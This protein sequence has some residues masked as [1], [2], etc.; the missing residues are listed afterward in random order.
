M[1]KK[2][3]NN[4]IKNIIE[5]RFQRARVYLLQNPNATIL[6]D[7]YYED[8]Q[9]LLKEYS[10]SFQQEIDDAFEE[11]KEEASDKILSLEDELEDAENKIDELETNIERLQEELDDT[12]NIRGLLEGKL[13]ILEEEIEKLQEKVNTNTYKQ[14]L[15]EENNLFS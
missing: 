8:V 6:L 13:H 15:P 12:H 9:C 14:F 4:S 2:Y 1:A 10:G 5:D 3:L 11:G 7:T